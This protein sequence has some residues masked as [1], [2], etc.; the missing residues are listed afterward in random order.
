[1][2]HT[3][4]LH[5]ASA[6][7]AGSPVVSEAVRRITTALSKDSTTLNPDLYS[8][9]LRRSFI[10]SVDQAHAMHPNYRKYVLYE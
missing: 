2:F 3:A 7:G 6:H 5:I 4:L 1:M 9:S 8:A 10:F